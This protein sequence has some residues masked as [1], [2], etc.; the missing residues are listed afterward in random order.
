[1]KQKVHTW[2]TKDSLLSMVKP[3]SLSSNFY[4]FEKGITTWQVWVSDWVSEE[5]Y[6]L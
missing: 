1:M 2:N 5:K 4:L 3:I 6:R